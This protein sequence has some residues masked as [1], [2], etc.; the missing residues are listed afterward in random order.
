MRD[1]GPGR[2]DRWAESADR[3][4]DYLRGRFGAPDVDVVDVVR[5]PRGVSRETWLVKLESAS[6]DVPSGVTI[7]RNLRG[8]SVDATPLRREFEVYRRLAATDVP[9]ARVLWYEDEPERWMAGP[10]FYVRELIDGSWQIPH[11]DDPDPAYDD[12]RIAASKEHLRALA[13]VHTCDWEALGFGDVLDAPPSPADAARHALD[14]VQARVESLRVEAL[15]EIT[16]G[17]AWLRRNAPASAPRISL[18]KGTN[19]LGEEVWRDGVLVAMSDWEL[20]SLGDPTYDFAQMQAMVPDVRAGD[21]V[22]WDLTLAL[23]FYRQESGIDIDPASIAWYRT[24]YLV[25]MASYASN[26]AKLLVEREDDLARLAWVATEI[27]FF[28]R[29]GLATAAATGPTG[30]NN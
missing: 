18:C 17:I 29:L 20:A 14:H 6:D 27:L 21:E 15:P 30:G 13:R 9:I 23:D 24:L 19:G 4:R 25:E 12:L 5:F 10:E 28:A 3:L 1:D 26:S 22:R 8:G 11:F 16:E 7:R 2:T